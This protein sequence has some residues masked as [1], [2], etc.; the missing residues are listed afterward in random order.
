MDARDGSPGVLVQQLFDPFGATTSQRWRDRRAAWRARED[1]VDTGRLAL[2]ELDERVAKDFV[3]RH[4][5]SGAYPAARMR[6]GLVD[7]VADRLLG[8]LVLGVPMQAKVLSNVFP[9]LAPGEAAELSRLVLLDDEAAGANAES[10]FVS[11]AFRAAAERGLRGV[12]A[13]S[14]PVPRRRVDG[15]T[16]MPGHVGIVYQATNAAYLGRASARSLVLLPDATVLTARAISKLVGL[17]RGHGYVERRLVALG[18]EPR[19]GMQPRAWLEEA[20]RVI[21]ARRVSHPGNFRYAWAVGDRAA[22]RQ[23][24]VSGTAGPY[25]KRIDSGLLVA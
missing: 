23:V 18:A 11:R 22:R 14:D 24:V 3:C 10:Y 17:E 12:V 6:Y 19:G 1:L 13:F 7:R 2:V 16:V 8:V 21:G 4:H 15:T 5:Y 9:E 20:L 25:P